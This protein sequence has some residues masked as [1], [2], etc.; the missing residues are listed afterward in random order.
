[1]FWLLT[2]LS[3]VQAGLFHDLL[4]WTVLIGLY[5]AYV[6]KPSFRQ[7][8]IA[9]LAGFVLIFLIQIVKQEYRQ[10]IWSQQY[11]GDPVHL[12]TR[13]V[14]ERI[15]DSNI[16]FDRAA[17]AD[18]VIRLNQGWINSRVMEQVPRNEPFA[19]GG[20]I[21]EVVSAAFSLR[22][23]IPDKKIA[24]GK[25]NYERFTGFQ[26]QRTTS[27]G[28]SLLGEGYANYGLYGAWLFLGGMG[29][30]YGG[31][32]HFLYRFSVAHPT[33]LLWL[34]LIFLQ[35]IKAETELAVVLNHLVKSLILVLVVFW[36]LSHFTRWRI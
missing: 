30:F 17:Y 13:L 1:M 10:L 6:F 24:G 27:M 15:Q 12:Y 16:F 26:L 19:R 7:K 28:V 34:P 23:F 11:E 25:A 18:L 14:S 29:L 22:F 33:I 3:S 35:V 36:F 8:S 31:V 32:L 2:L 20:T 4:L 21:W 5:A 9:L